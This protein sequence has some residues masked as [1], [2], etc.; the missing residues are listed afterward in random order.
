MVTHWEGKKYRK[1]SPPFTHGPFSINLPAAW[2]R[3]CNVWITL[4][5]LYRNKVSLGSIGITS[6]SIPEGKMSSAAVTSTGLIWRM[7]SCSEKR[8]GSRLNK[9][10]AAL[11]K[12]EDYTHSTAAPSRLLLGIGDKRTRRFY[13]QQLKP[14]PPDWRVNISAAH[15]SRRVVVFKL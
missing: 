7:I 5:V 15:V 4:L 12:N 1:H 8:E 14:L 9:R 13:F 10:V 6:L 3:Q 11:F 2:V